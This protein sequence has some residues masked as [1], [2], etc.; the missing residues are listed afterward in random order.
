MYVCAGSSTLG[1]DCETG[2]VR[3]ANYSDDFDE[4]SRQG[5]L[6]I[7]VNNVWGVV[8]SDNFFDTRDAEVFCEELD[9]FESQG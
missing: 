2:D 5:R 8:C 9:G 7:C 3:L 1:A 6:E 4:F